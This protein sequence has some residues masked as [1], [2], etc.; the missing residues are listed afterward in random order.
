MNSRQRSRYEAALAQIGR[1]S[2]SA[3][4]IL[5]ETG[6]QEACWEFQALAAWSLGELD[7][8]TRGRAPRDGDRRLFNLLMGAGD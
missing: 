3:A 1:G 5:D 4:A 7:R 8:S 2:R 6:Q